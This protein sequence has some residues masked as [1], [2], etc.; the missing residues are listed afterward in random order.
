LN[1]GPSRKGT[2]G[3]VVR[4]LEAWYSTKENCWTCRQGTGGMFLREKNLYKHGGKN[5]RHSLLPELE[6]IIR[7]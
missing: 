1:A 3:H 6:G 4:E 2:T 7:T 5:W